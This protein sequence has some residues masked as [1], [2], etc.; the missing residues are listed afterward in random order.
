MHNS[1]NVGRSSVK[2]YYYCYRRRE[3][4]GQRGEGRGAVRLTL[5]LTE[6]G[7][8]SK[9]KIFAEHLTK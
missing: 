7:K 9:L 5:L 2:F 1:H 3:G 8:I 6:T 4:R